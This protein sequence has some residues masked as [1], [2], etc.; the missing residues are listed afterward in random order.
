LK[1]GIYYA[2]ESGP[3]PAI[4]FFSFGT[5]KVTKV[6]EVDSLPPPWDPGFAVSPDEKRIIFSQ[7]DRSAIDLMLVEN[8]R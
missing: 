5:R 7:V 2:D 8:F 6:V 1:R 4:D 3:R